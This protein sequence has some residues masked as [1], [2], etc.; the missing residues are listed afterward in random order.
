MKTFT[1]HM[2]GS[3][4]D[5]KLDNDQKTSEYGS[6]EEKVTL[7]DDGIPEKIGKKT[8]EKLFEGESERAWHGY[9]LRLI[10]K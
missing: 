9:T 8:V 5:A 3:L 4:K 2:G 7:Y 6:K 10:R 1:E